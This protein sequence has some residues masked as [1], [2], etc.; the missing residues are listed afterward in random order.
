[1]AYFYDGVISTC[2]HMGG[3]EVFDQTTTAGRMDLW[4]AIFDEAPVAIAQEM[5]GTSANPS[6]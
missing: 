1:M 4:E 6:P 2:D 5:L 3:A